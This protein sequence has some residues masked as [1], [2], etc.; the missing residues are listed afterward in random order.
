M[1]FRG[2]FELREA[3]A[4]FS[5]SIKLHPNHSDTYHGRAQVLREMGDFAEALANHD[6]AI[7]L[8]P[9]QFDLYWQRGLTDLRIRAFDD[10]IADFE[11][12][13]ERN[14]A[15]TDAQRGLERAQ[16]GRNDFTTELPDLEF[17]RTPERKPE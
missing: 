1:T 13:L 8:A 15:F 16:R 2:R 12:C 4:A 14:P 7:E 17:A 5:A 3:L 10:A 9:E 6:R 11:Q